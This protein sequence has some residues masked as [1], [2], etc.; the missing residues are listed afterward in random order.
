MPGRGPEGPGDG[1]T[2]NPFMPLAERLIRLRDTYE[3]DCAELL[4]EAVGAAL[5]RLLCDG[6][7]PGCAKTRWPAS[8]KRLLMTSIATSSACVVNR[9][10][11]QMAGNLRRLRLTTPKT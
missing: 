8:T 5:S 10:N 7:L 1:M 6:S 4:K 9:R 3:A 2:N 11:F